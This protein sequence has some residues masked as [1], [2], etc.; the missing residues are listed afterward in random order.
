[1][2]TSSSTLQSVNYNEKSSLLLGLVDR[3]KLGSA[4]GDAISILGW[5]RR[6]SIRSHFPV[7]GFRATVLRVETSAF[8]QN[9]LLVILRETQ[10]TVRV[11]V[12]RTMR[13]MS[14]QERR[15][16]TLSFHIISSVFA[17][18]GL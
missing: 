6:L 11:L 8:S 9:S 16:H 14:V 13:V 15:G 17:N 2:D 4:H 18:D 7:P 3:Y 12:T 10:R 1:M 5:Q